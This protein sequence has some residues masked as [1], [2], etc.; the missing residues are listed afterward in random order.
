[1]RKQTWKKHQHKNH[2]DLPKTAQ[3]DLAYFQKQIICKKN[4]IHVF[5]II[6]IDSSCRG[7][8]EEKNK[9]TVPLKK[10]IKRL[11]MSLKKVFMY[12]LHDEH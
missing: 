4:E 9:E 12:L 5:S 8:R 2:P 7:R 10:E 6:L 3:K 11:R 1:M